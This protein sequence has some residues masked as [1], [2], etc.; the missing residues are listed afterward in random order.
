MYYSRHILC[1]GITNTV[2]FFIILNAETLYIL[3]TSKSIIIISYRFKSIK[4]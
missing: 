3:I 2:I 1:T 4:I